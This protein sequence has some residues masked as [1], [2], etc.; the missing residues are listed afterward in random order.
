MA[1]SKVTQDAIF[2]DIDNLVTTQQAIVSHDEQEPPQ[3]PPKSEI[4]EEK[5]PDFE[6]S[7]S[8]F[9]KIGDGLNAYVEYKVHVKM[10]AGNFNVVRRYSEFNWLRDKLL[11]SNKGVIVPPLPEKTLLKNF[12]SEV[13]EYRRRELEK[14]LVR[15]LSHHTLCK[16][17]DLMAF[18]RHHNEALTSLKEKEQPQ[19]SS[20]FFS[21]L[22]SSISNQIESISSQV[23]SQKEPDQWFEAKKELHFC[24]R[25]SI[26]ESC[27]SN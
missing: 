5:V 7:L 11:E 16:S 12:N 20:G 4:P 15:V 17:K 26:D 24:F 25:K 18:L 9:E 3:I 27:K 22:G 13:L 19:Q 21:I 6:V 10:E 1:N 23:W 2:D 8:A 14:F